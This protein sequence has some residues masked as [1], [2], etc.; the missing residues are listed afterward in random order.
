MQAVNASEASA[1]AQGGHRLGGMFGGLRGAAQRFILGRPQSGSEAVGETPSTALHA[2][3]TAAAADSAAYSPGDRVMYTGPLGQEEATVRLVERDEDG[4]RY[5]LSVAS[6]GREVTTVR[7]RLRPAGVTNTVTRSR[8]AAD[9]E[10]RAQEEADAELARALQAEEDAASAAMGDQSDDGPPE[11]VYAPEM[12]PDQFTSA[13]STLLQSVLS[14]QAAAPQQPRGAGGSDGQA[15]EQQPAATTRQ[16]ALPGGLGHVVITTGSTA[17]PPMPMFGP[18]AG[19]GG[20][21]E[22]PVVLGPFGPFIMGGA[23]FG[24][25]LPFGG[26]PFGGM[27]GGLMPDDDMPL[28]YEQLLALQERLGGTVPRGATQAQIESLPTRRYV[29]SQQA[30]DNADTCAICLST[31]EHGEELR[32]LPCAHAFHCGCIDR[33]MQASKKCPTCRAELP[34]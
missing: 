32:T 20:A 31:Y 18:A 13:F 23:P 19:G 7:A 33:W 24:A 17:A 9:A 11:L 6:D 29:A 12:A 30:G 26:L 21:A 16:F 2:A 5:V 1:P 22:M 15:Q 25:G 10:R 3:R 14:Q 4:F 8:E 28:S 34:G 27:F